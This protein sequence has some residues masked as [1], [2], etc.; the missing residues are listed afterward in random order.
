MNDVEHEQ[1]TTAQA[2]S[3]L[4]PTSLGT[5]RRSN[6]L[7]FQDIMPLLCFISVERIGQDLHE[8]P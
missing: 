3:W 2:S 6:S 8:S 7:R 1:S 4:L 5:L